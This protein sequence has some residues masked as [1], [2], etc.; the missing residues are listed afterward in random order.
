V[1]SWG[2]LADSRWGVWAS[3]RVIVTAE[4]IVPRSVIASEPHLTLLPGFRVNAV[5]HAPWGA[6]PMP[7]TGCYYR[8]PNWAK[9][10]G[11]PMRD[12]ESARDYLDR[13][14]HG[15]G[16]RAAYIAQYRE[17]FGDDMLEAIRAH[18]RLTPERPAHYGWR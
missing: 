13:W 1:Q 18:E 12:W 2:P 8:D 9:Q 10:T 14:V 11:F 15:T 6:H 17:V 4:E 7:L 16:D 3:E 5:V